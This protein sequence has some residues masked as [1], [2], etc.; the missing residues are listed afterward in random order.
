V[1]HSLGFIIAL[2]AERTSLTPL[3]LAHHAP[4]Q[5][6]SGQWVVLSG[7]GAWA[8][9]RAARQLLEK[10]VTGLV[11]WGSAGALTHTLQPGDLVLPERILGATGDLYHT[12]SGWRSRLSDAL[13]TDLPLTGGLLIESLAVIA[14]PEDKQFLHATTTAVAVDM[15]SAA[16]AAVARHGE[17][18]FVA[19]RAIA[20]TVHMTLPGSIRHAVDSDGRLRMPKLLSHAALH[21]GEWLALKR[22]GTAFRSAHQTL[23]TVS[24]RARVEHFFFSGP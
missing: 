7:T 15:E 1:N 23:H 17:I 6:S 5:L 12:E 13:A 18:P 22:L 4:R 9:H 11:S 16:I 8:A 19:I 3:K 2:Q 21:P 20:D 24:E 14:T 10:G